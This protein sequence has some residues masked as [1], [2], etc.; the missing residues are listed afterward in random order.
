MEPY[1]L[2]LSIRALFTRKTFCITFKLEGILKVLKNEDCD[3]VVNK[4]VPVAAVDLL[5]VLNRAARASFFISSARVILSTI[6]GG[7]P[8]SQVML[9]NC[10]NEGCV[11]F[12]VMTLYY[13]H[14]LVTR[15]N[16]GYPYLRHPPQI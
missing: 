12:F 14:K 3:P 6:E 1:Q 5:F 4:G 2:C 7:L 9:S 10:D 13:N 15:L 16:H 8:V 11:S